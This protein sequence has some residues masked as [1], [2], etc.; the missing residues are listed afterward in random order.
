MGPSGSLDDDD[1]ATCSPLFSSRPPEGSWRWDLRTPGRRD[2]TALGGLEA[3]VDGLRD[4]DEVRGL[5]AAP[6]PGRIPSTYRLVSG[7]AHFWGVAAVALVCPA[8]PAASSSLAVVSL[9]GTGPAGGLSSRPTSSWK[10][11]TSGF[12]PGASPSLQRRGRAVRRHKA[13]TESLTSHPAPPGHLWMSSPPGVG[14]GPGATLPLALGT[15]VRTRATEGTHRCGRKVARAGGTG[16]ARWGPGGGA[17]IP[18]HT[19]KPWGGGGGCSVYV[20]CEGCGCGGARLP[21]P[22][23][24][25]RSRRDRRV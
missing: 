18:P 20:Q 9:L 10:P 24:Y 11:A 6:T 16:G 13:G 12:P 3:C 4:K 15:C 22:F 1:D 17:G 21:A 25:S 19:G 14:T 7:S 2:S 5:S 8:I 23:C